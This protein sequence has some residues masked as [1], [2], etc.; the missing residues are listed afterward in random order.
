MNISIFSYFL[1]F[2]ISMLWG[3]G[4]MKDKNGNILISDIILVFILSLFS[5]IFVL[6]L[7]LGWL[8]KRNDKN[9]HTLG[10]SGI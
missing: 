5:W 10:G 4:L 7:F 3:T 8:T 6:A 2:L 1:G 9:N